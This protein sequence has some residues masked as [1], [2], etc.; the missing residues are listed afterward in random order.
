MN[1]PS[2]YSLKRRQTMFNG[3]AV[4]PSDVWYSPQQLCVASIYSFP[5]FLGNYLYIPELNHFRSDPRSHLTK[6]DT[7]NGALRD[8]YAWSQTMADVDIKVFV[9]ATV[10]VAKQLSVEIKSDHIKV[11]VVLKMKLIWVGTDMLRIY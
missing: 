3:K 5:N 7:Y 8:G 6:A 4:S 2:L 1:D 10:K 11:S 9:P